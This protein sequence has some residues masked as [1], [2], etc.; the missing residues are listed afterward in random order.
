MLN[1]SFAGAAPRGL[2]D[3]PEHTKPLAADGRR[4]RMPPVR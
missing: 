2:E 3:A 4:M 1:P